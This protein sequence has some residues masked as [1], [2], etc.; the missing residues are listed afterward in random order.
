MHFAIYPCRPSSQ[1]SLSTVTIF[2]CHR[3]PLYLIE[4]QKRKK[5]KWTNLLQLTLQFFR[6]QQLRMWTNTNFCNKLLFNEL[7]LINSTWFKRWYQNKNN[8]FWKIHCKKNEMKMR[9][10][11]RDLKLVTTHWCVL[12]VQCMKWKET[13][14]DWLHNGADDN[15][16]FNLKR[17]HRLDAIVFHF[18]VKRSKK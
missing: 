17:K 18:R 6:E 13:S 1:Y 14:L 8:H 5:F 2:W 9:D 10:C 11:S 4:K 3:V 12:C 16:R 15:S 7:S